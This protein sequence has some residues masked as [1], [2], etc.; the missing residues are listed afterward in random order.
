MAPGSRASRGAG[1]Y[2]TPKPHA[3]CPATSALRTL[4]RLASAAAS[5]SE[6]DAMPPLTVAKLV[7]PPVRYVGCRGALKKMKLYARRTILRRELRHGH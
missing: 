7:A 5:L 1:R 6:S 3:T 4:A 2:P